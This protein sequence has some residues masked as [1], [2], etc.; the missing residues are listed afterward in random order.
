MY[1]LESKLETDIF[2]YLLAPELEKDIF[3]ILALTAPVC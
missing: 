2:L 1:Y 3:V